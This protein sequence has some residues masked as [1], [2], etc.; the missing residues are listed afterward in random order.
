[1]TLEHAIM[2]ALFGLGICGL[3][4]FWRTEAD[5]HLGEA[6]REEYET[7][8]EQH[9]MRA[10]AL[11]LAHQ[12]VNDLAFERKAM[13]SR[14]WDSIPAN[15]SPRQSTVP[16]PKLRLVRKNVVPF[17]RGNHHPDDAA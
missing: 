5:R 8:R 9:Q 17:R 7:R 6:L 11:E 2:I 14:P 10:T 3:C 4:Y 12:H 16:R 13:A 1:M 15:P